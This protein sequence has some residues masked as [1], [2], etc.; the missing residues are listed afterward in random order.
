MALER[1]DRHNPSFDKR[2]AKIAERR[3]EW[4]NKRCEGN[5]LDIGCG[6][7]YLAELNYENDKVTSYLGLDYNEAAIA[8]AERFNNN[9][10]CQF[11]LY[12]T[13]NEK[14]IYKADT[15]V[16]TEFLEHIEKPIQIK[17]LKEIRDIF[18]K[19]KN[20]LLVGSTPMQPNEGPNPSGNHYHVWEH[21]FESFKEMIE[22]IFNNNYDIKL[23]KKYDCGHCIFFEVEKK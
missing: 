19:Q 12:D 6:F 13:R 8:K 21:T 17:L 5:V 9:D 20:G 4:A 15:I 18:D 11:R 22:S 10:E 7:G 2:S 3:L 16:C 1:Y 14:I 23:I